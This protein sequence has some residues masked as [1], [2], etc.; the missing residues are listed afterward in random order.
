MDR[1]STG[2]YGVITDFMKRQMFIIARRARP[3][4]DQR[5]GRIGRRVDAVR[6]DPQL[7]A[8]IGIHVRRYRLAAFV[9]SGALGGSPAG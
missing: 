3:G 1:R 7:A 2:L 5:A 6:D 8:S 9:V 4:G